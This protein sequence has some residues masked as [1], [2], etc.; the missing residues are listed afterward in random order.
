MFIVLLIFIAGVLFLIPFLPALV[1][2]LR[3][4]DR[5]PLPLLNNTGAEIRATALQAEIARLYPGIG[6][7]THCGLAQAQNAILTAAKAGQRAW[8]EPVIFAEDA[9]MPPALE[10]RRELY[11]AQSFRSGHDCIFDAIYCEGSLYLGEQTTVNGWVHCGSALV[12]GAGSRTM[13]PARA[14]SSL[15][16][17]PGCHFQYL[18]APLI[19][20]AGPQT[21]IPA[22][23]SAGPRRTGRQRRLEGICEISGTCLDDVV[24]KGEMRIRSGS[25]VEGDLKSQKNIVIEDGCVLRGSVVSA[26]DLTI[27]RGCSVHGPVIAEGLITFG[28]GSRAGNL[29]Q[30]TSLCAPRIRLRHGSVVHGTISATEWG[31]VDSAGEAA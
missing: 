27:G 10:F 17:G 24:A 11:S 5:A 26:G 1:E 13:G 16:A 28:E 2:W 30:P 4:R 8:E 15:Q 14:Q 25:V 7:T 20:L 19:T 3:P 29:A 22:S 12:L 18:H 9:N 21:W 6:K 31:R 23:A